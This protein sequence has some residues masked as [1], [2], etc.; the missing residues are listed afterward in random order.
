MRLRIAAIAGLVFGTAPLAGTA[1][2]FTP[3][4]WVYEVTLTATKFGHG[5]IFEAKTSAP[6]D[7]EVPA[8]CHA[9]EPSSGT[10]W[11]TC[12]DFIP[13]G[14]DPLATID[15]SFAHLLTRTA[16]IG[17]NSSSVVC[18]AWLIGRCPSDGMNTPEEDWPDFLGDYFYENV[19]LDAAKG[20]LSYCGFRIGAENACYE[21]SPKGVSVGDY[22]F[23]NVSDVSGSW[24]FGDVGKWY[25]SGDTDFLYSGTGQL[26]S[27]PVVPLPAPLLMLG[28]ALGALGIAR[29]AGRRR[30]AA[31][32]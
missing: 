22:V 1:A 28:S 2:T 19:T 18:D 15:L 4:M 25:S 27:T 26:V 5:E 16:R 29:A 10:I 32:A 31:R 11:V 12:H 14:L 13:E 30:R 20:Y 24:N 17:F 9:G 3:D 21:L 23:L 8:G 6:A 7:A